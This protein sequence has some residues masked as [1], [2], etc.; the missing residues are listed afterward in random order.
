LELRGA[1]SEVQKDLRE[2]LALQLMDECKPEPNSEMNVHQ[3]VKYRDG[4]MLGFVVFA[5]LRPKNLVSLEI[6]CHLVLEG[7]RW[8]II[9]PRE[10]TKTR[11]RIEFEIPKLLVP[12][13]TTY[14]AIVRPTILRGRTHTALW[15]SANGGALCYVG[16]TKSFARLSSRLGVLFSPHDARDAAADSPQR[17]EVSK[18]AQTTPSC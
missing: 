16:T 12:Y 8:F 7:D 5:P 11:K 3:A 15:V 4:L 13:L 17:E 9:V 18:F 10:E 1:R 2:E 14:L 6:G